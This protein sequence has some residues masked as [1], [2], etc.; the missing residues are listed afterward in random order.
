M[1]H[2]ISKEKNSKIELEVKFEAA[3]FMAFWNK[4]FKAVQTEIEIDG[5]RKGNAPENMI[6]AKYGESAI[7][8]E[9]AN[10]AINESYPKIILEE[11]QK[12]NI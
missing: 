5:F 8:N 11:S 4:A 10:I 7:I 3:E 12:N 9:M 2:K 1:T 6:V